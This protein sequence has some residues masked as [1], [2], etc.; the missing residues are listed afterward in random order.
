MQQQ[1]SFAELEY[2]NKKRQTRRELF[3][4][5]MET[6][7]PWANLLSCIEPHYPKAGRRGRQPMPLASMFRGTGEVEMTS[8]RRDA[9][10]ADEMTTP[11]L[12]DDVHG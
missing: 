5:E 10:A 9:L 2:R 6:V 7:V 12:G 1:T 3:L 4:A 11:D 8:N